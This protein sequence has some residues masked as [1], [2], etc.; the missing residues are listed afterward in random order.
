MIESIA[1]IGIVCFFRGVV[2][3]VGTFRFIRSTSVISGFMFGLVGDN[4]AVDDDA[5]TGVTFGCSKY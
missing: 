3:S 2:N 5:F 4:K 1:V